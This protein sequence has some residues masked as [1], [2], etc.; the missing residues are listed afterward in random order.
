[1]K[2]LVTGATGQLGSDVIAQL[3]QRSNLIEPIAIGSKDCDITKKNEVFDVILSFNPQIIIH[4]AAF[5]QVDNCET[6]QDKAY[7]VNALGTSHLIQAADQTGAYVVYI[8]TDYVFDG[9]LT[10]PYNEFDATNPLSV[11]G[12]S[13]LAGEHFM[14]PQDLIIRISWVCGKVGS[15][16][17]KTVL[18]LSEKNEP[19]KF[20]NDQIGSPTFTFDAAKTIVNLALDKTAGTV[21]LTNSGTTSW[22]G[23]AREIYSVIGKDPNLI[24][25]I[26]TEELVPPRPAPRPKNSVL[27]NMVLRIY[28]IEPLPPWQESL[29]CLVKELMW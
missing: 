20:V 24:I 12:R 6:Q 29:A 16:M 22:W 2:V 4:C 28:S 5:T 14:R 9:S 1:M 21:H 18:K 19:V 26:T 17:V 11:Y 3:A 8:S 25:P 27:D 10:R 23:F 15:N 7:A 13:K